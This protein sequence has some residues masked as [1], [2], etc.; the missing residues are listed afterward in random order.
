DEDAAG[1]AA[2]AD[3]GQLDLARALGDRVDGWSELDLTADVDVLDGDERAGQSRVEG[4]A[5]GGSAQHER[6]GLV[7]VDEAV[8]EDGD[9]D[10]LHHLVDA[11]GQPAARRR[12]VARRH[13]AAGG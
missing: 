12:V 10:G 11:K 13:V 6:E 3:D 5:A 1:G 9:G 4:G 8:L 7:A 2:G